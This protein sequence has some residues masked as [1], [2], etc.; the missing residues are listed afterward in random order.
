MQKGMPLIGH[1]YPKGESV[2]VEERTSWENIAYCI[3]SACE[4]GMD[5]VKTTYCGN[6]DVWPRPCP[7][8]PAASV[9]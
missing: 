1:V 8:Y 7:L 6:P 2:P 4:M 9:L 3:R 5:I